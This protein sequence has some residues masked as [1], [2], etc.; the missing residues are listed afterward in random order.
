MVLVLV[1][2]NGCAPKVE[3]EIRPADWPYWPTAMRIHPL[4]RFV[5]SADDQLPAIEARIEF[6]DRD[7]DITK[8]LGVLTIRLYD[9]PPDGGFERVIEQWVVDLGELG[10]NRIRFEDITRTYLAL[11]KFDREPRL[12]TR[13]ELRASF[14]SINGLSFNAAIFLKPPG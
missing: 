5:R 3:P 10:E 8:A 1:V 2:G 4:T 11:L 9:L 7:D 6:T 13:L 14:V 12:G